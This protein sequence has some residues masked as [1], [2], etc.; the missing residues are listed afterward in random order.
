MEQVQ[1]VVQAHLDMA[2]QRGITIVTGGDE[3]LCIKWR[4]RSDSGGA[5]K[6]D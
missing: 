6:I 3:S 5:R 2:A 4:S 1:A